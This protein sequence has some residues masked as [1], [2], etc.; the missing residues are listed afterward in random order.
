MDRRKARILPATAHRRGWAAAAEGG[1]GGEIMAFSGSSAGCMAAF[2]YFFY[3]KTL[4]RR[5]TTTGSGSSRMP[6]RSYTLVWIARA[7]VITS[8]PVTLS[9]PRPRLTSTSAC[10]S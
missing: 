7:S 8:P 6:K 3:S 2:S 10:F 1:R 9:A 5:Q 4:P